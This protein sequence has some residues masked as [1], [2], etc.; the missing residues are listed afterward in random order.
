MINLLV[1]LADNDHGAV[2]GDTASLVAPAILA[3]PI[4]VTG[5]TFTLS[6]SPCMILYLIQA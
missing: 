5:S 3:L 2:T 4:F 6:R 1:P